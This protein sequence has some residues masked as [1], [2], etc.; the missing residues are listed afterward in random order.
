MRGF[1]HNLF[2]ETDPLIPEEVDLAVPT[3]DEAAGAPS[4][5]ENFE[6]EGE[7]SGY[8]GT[9]LSK[10]RLI[11]F[12]GVVFLGLS[13]LAA[14]AGYLELIEGES[15]RTLAEGNRIRVV[16]IESERGIIYDRNGRILARNIPDFT[17]TITPAD[18]P[19]EKEERDRL[20][21]RLA[22]ML[23]LTPVEIERELSRHSPS[24]T[25]A[26]PIRENLDYDKALLLDVQSGTL[27]GVTLGLGTKREY[28]LDM[29]ERSSPVTSL[30]HIL[31]YLGRINERE[32]DERRDRGYL[33]T[34]SVGKTG[35]EASYEDYLR[36]VYGKKQIEVDAFGREQQVLAQKD[37]IEGR[38]LTLSIDMRLQAEAERI[39]RTS[40]GLNG[41]GRGAAVAMDPRTGEIL[42]LVSWPAYDANLFSGG[43]SQKDF[44]AL[45]EDENRPLFPRAVSGTFPPGS[46]LK[47]M[48]A[49][50]ALNEGIADPATSFIS[51]GG[52]RIGQWFFPDWKFGGHGVTNVVKAISESVNTY[53]YAIGGGWESFDGLGVER[54]GS[55]LRRFGLGS[56][57]GIDLP[58]EA[59]GFVPTIEWKEEAKGEPWYIGDTY[60]LAIGQGDVLVTPLQVASW[61]ATFANGGDL[62]RPTLVKRDE[63]HI[64]SAEV[65]P[66]DVVA[67]VRRGMRETIIGQRGSARGLQTSFVEIAG[68][69]GTAQW[70]Q[71]EP[72]HA[73]FT[74]F[75]PY[76][77]PEIVV[78]VLIEAGGEG[79]SVGAPTAR[80]IIETWMR[81]KDAPYEP[82]PLPET[83]I[84]G[85][86]D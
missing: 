69:T 6:P 81:L 10:R 16:P 15:Y 41:P 52:I 5:G 72:N 83:P 64:L 60:H 13:A 77:D 75:A 56:P 63:P 86:E 61:T 40:A 51:S 68:K 73:W 20:I 38:D 70:R 1:D 46:T 35:I 71:G 36:G 78:T 80:E 65:V 29:P 74:G 85:T 21:V 49:A 30:S 37:A 2:P 84:D 23:E 79:S 32:Y 18:L 43:I 31:G 44:T 33:P 19:Q 14:R 34:D 3:I 17:L 12:F 59:S 42:A 11:I 22:E 27:P 57:L 47:L 66:P 7:R 4:V 28:L 48:V 24:T 39:I 50:A 25:S 58:G 67:T 62:V 26:V 9:S 76:D 8:L 54:L 82:E 53:F 45:I 55:Y